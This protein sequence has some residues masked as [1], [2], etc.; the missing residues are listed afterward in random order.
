MCFNIGIIDRSVRV[1]L[2]VALIAYGVVA[3]NY[4]V[5]AIGAIPLL[6]AVF[7]ICPLYIPFKINTGCKRGGEKSE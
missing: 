4:I 7:G 6:T 1:V 2:G 5:A 3:P